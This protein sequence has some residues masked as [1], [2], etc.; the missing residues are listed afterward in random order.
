MK[1]IALDTFKDMI[2][3]N[4]IKLGNSIVIERI[5]NSTSEGRK[6][7]GE[8]RGFDVEAAQMVEE[9]LE[10]VK[11]H[12]LKIDLFGF[13][14]LRIGRSLDNPDNLEIVFDMNKGDDEALI[15][16]ISAVKVFLV[17]ALIVS[18]LAFLAAGF[19]VLKKVVT[20]MSGHHQ[21][22]IYGH[23]AGGY[24]DHGIESLPSAYGYANYMSHYPT[25]GAS[26]HGYGTSGG[27]GGGVSASEDLQAH[28][29][30]NVVSTVQ[31][32]VANQTAT[33]RDGNNWDNKYKMNY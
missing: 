8:S 33:R 3:T 18:K 22:Y 17:K 9:V 31:S 10:F 13:A 30:N 21:P 23:H 27:G 24:Y 7:E 20:M 6:M 14:K 26:L 28:F 2:K 15:F 11:N 19:L 32:R 1:S 25:A 4:E 12:A 29:S 16:G 5:G